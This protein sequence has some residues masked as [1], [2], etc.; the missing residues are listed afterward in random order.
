MSVV[1]KPISLDI[2]YKQN[3][4]RREWNKKQKRAYHR[5]LS[6]IKKWHILG[7]QLKFMTLTSSTWVNVDKLNLHFQTLRY[8]INRKFGRMEYFKIKTN[9][10]N[11]VLHILFVGNYVPQSWLSQNWSKIH[12]GS[13]IVDIRALKGSDKKLA[14]YLV[15]QYVSGQSFIRL[16]W[17]WK[18]VY[19]GFV[20]DWEKI[21]WRYENYGR[22]K[23]LKEWDKFLYRAC[24]KDLKINIF[25]I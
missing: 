2:L 3:S 19:K 7:K 21:K 24:Y 10:G 6:G 15:S 23:I 11:G 16:S 25:N 12:N 18:W 4:S 1:E 9:E 22:E 17:S 5:C 8:R 20:Q 14:R 13:V